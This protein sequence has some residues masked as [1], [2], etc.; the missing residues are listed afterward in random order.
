M[1]SQK[2]KIKNEARMGTR[3]EIQPE[4]RVIMKWMVA[5]GLAKALDPE[6]RSGE[7]RCAADEK[8]CDC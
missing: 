6:R 5:K 3:S 4:L 2:E 1:N 8:V 7:S